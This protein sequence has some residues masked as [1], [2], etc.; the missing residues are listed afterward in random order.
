MI[1]TLPTRASY[2][3]FLS[4]AVEI[5][6]LML[7]NQRRMFERDLHATT[8]TQAR[9]KNATIEFQED[10]ASGGWNAYS[11]SDR[12]VDASTIFVNRVLRD[13]LEWIATTRTATSHEYCTSASCL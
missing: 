5:A 2:P 7:H 4:K 1:L 10:T 6:N 13:R 8:A 12:S 11:W 9:L 3:P